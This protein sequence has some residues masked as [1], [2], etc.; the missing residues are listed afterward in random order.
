MDIGNNLHEMEMTERVAQLLKSVQSERVMVKIAD[1]ALRIET[2]NAIYSEVTGFS[3]A[4]VVGTRL[5]SR[6]NLDAQSLREMRAQ[7]RGGQQWRGT[8]VSR[9]KDLQSYRE[10]V[11]VFPIF[12][13]DAVLSHL[14]KVAEDISERRRT[15]ATVRFLAFYDNLTHLPNRR[16]FADRLEQ[17]LT[18]NT[19]TGALLAVLSLNLDGFAGVNRGLGPVLDDRMLQVLARRLILGLRSSDTA[20]HFAG[21]CFK[22]ILSKINQPENVGKVAAKLLS[23]L[24]APILLQGQDLHVTASV[25]A[26]IFPFDGSD[27]ETLHKHA[28]IAVQR[29]REEGPGSYRLF[30]P[31]LHAR[32][33]RRQALEATLR[34]C[35]RENNFILHYQPLLDLDADR[36]VGVEALVRMPHPERELIPPAEFIPLAE[37]TRLILPLGEW[38]L[39]EACRQLRSWQSAGLDLPSVSVNL[40]PLQLKGGQ[41]PQLV[42]RIL[43]ET[44]LD[45]ACLEL[46]VTESA[47][48]NDL[49]A[50]IASL[51][52]L[53]ELGLSIV[54]DDFGTGYSSLNYLKRLPLG[55]IKIDRSFVAD[56]AEDPADSAIVG[57]V[58]A[59]AGNLDIKVLVE[60][61]ETRR[62]QEVLAGLGCRLMQGYYFSRPLPAEQLFRYVAERQEGRP[63]EA[64]RGAGPAGF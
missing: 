13:R 44:G 40:S 60:G 33:V 23:L 37:L 57:S 59:L 27:S 17:A 43:A 21:D 10:K 30:S 7:L 4:E 14:V 53:K 16:L 38:V 12:N 11:T 48:M 25:G 29:A 2:V 9:R 35:L 55:M 62:Q 8:L 49:E 5:F 39:R 47:L 18:L 24:G 52:A 46:E 54:L 1:A 41:L 50:C 3:A 36:V 20:A 42:A 22:I 61:V 45:P 34:T 64:W 51:K 15:E 31:E 58:V 56:I 28:D 63:A 6:S 19:R 26:A 32:A